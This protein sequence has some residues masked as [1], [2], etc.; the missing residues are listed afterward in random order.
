LIHFYKRH[1]PRE[2]FS[3]LRLREFRSGDQ[4]DGAV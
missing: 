4:Q 1:N 2:D 3:V